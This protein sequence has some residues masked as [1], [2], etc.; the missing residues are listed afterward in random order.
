MSLARQNFMRHAAL[1]AVPLFF[2]LAANSNPVLAADKC[3]PGVFSSSRG[4]EPGDCYT[5]PE[6][7]KAMAAFGQKT[8]IVGDRIAV[9]D[10][11]T[12]QVMTM[13][14]HNRWTSNDAGTLGFNLEGNAA[15]GQP[16]AEWG[17]GAV[18]KDVK[19]WDRDKR[20]QPPVEVV[21]RLNAQG[22]QKSGDRLMLSAKQGQGYYVVVARGDKPS[23][24]SF[25][26]ANDQKGA[27][28][29]GL[30]NLDYAP[31]GKE[32]LAQ[33]HASAP[34]VGSLPPLLA[35]GPSQQ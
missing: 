17:V 32:A 11:A 26:L 29:A 28:L 18:F 4:I 21:G 30:K 9:G 3:L 13:A 22:I 33:Q 14:R 12:G 20:E 10:D 1:A 6:I 27:G 24:G 7:N 23:V 35:S 25:L 19:L 5:T 16:Q 15:T 31:A 2:A 34:Q 8:R